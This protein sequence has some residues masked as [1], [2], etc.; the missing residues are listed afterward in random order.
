MVRGNS[1]SRRVKKSNPDLPIYVDKD[2]LQKEDDERSIL[3][4]KEPEII[5]PQFVAT[6][7]PT[8]MD[9]LKKLAEL[10]ELDIVTEDEF[11]HKK[12][13]FLGL[14]NKSPGLP[15]YVEKHD[16]QEEG[17][18]RNDQCSSRWKRCGCFSAIVVTA[19]LLLLLVCTPSDGYEC[20]REG[21]RL[22]GVDA[23][24]DDVLKFMERC[25]Y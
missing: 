21:D 11:E 23:G 15:I 10:K 13:Q 17:K 8:P 5:R 20:E 24:V 4:K 6:T 16:L 2:D 7:G 9:E 12:K 1:K 14:Q 19:L 18:E 25:E 22:F 3:A